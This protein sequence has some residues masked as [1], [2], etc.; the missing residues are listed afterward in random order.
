MIASMPPARHSRVGSSVTTERPAAIACSMA[1]TD[2]P[3]RCAVIPACEYASSACATL[4]FAIA[5]SRIPAHRADDL[6]RD[7]ACHVAGADHRYGH[8]SAF[9][10]A[11][12]ERCV[13]DDHG[14]VLA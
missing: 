4:R 6:E 7:A 13:D 10:L 1:A 9:L 12:L 5:T 14:L 3:A 8:R 11:L 2:P